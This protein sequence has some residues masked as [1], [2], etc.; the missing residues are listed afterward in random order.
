MVFTN[1]DVEV[2]YLTRALMGTLNKKGTLSSRSVITASNGVT[3][4]FHNDDDGGFGGFYAY[5]GTTQYAYQVSGGDNAQIISA[6]IQDVVDAIPDV[7]VNKIVGWQEG[8]TVVWYI[9]NTT[10]PYG[11]VNHVSMN[12]KSGGWSTWYMPYTTVVASRYMNSTTSVK[13]SYIANDS[14]K[15]LLRSGYGDEG[16]AIQGFLESKFLSGKDPFVY[17]QFNKMN[18]KGTQFAGSKVIAWGSADSEPVETDLQQNYASLDIFD[19]KIDVS[20]SAVKVR[21]PFDDVSRQILKGYRIDHNV[22]GAVT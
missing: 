7:N 18:I 1:D 13:N 12:L 19:A 6:P 17:Y 21:V 20:G 14:G 11:V 8:S 9:G 3:L 4:W 2:R 5:Q 16:A 10:M 15:I 22:S